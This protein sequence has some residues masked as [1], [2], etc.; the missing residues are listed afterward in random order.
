MKEM[1]DD[2]QFPVLIERRLKFLRSPDDIDIDIVVQVGYPKWTIPNIEAVCPVSF[3]GG[4]GR[5]KDI[6]GV[7]PLNAM[8][9]AITFIETYLSYP[10]GNGKFFWE[11][12][13][14]YDGG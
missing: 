10:E 13:E 3:V 14:E 7:D 1:N 12:G 9:Q 4:I 6:C 8:K 11:D 2:R 5:V